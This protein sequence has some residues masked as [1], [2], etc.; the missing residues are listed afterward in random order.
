MG[1]W[2]PSQHQLRPVS[3]PCPRGL[4]EPQSPRYRGQVWQPR[5]PWGAPSGVPGPDGWC[6][7]EADAGKGPGRTM[8]R[9]ARLSDVSG[10]EKQE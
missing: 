2:W 5:I 7:P 1:S 9:G 4:L 8:G 10:P 6:C 3:R